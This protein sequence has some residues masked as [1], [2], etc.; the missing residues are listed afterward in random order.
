MHCVVLV[1]I[2]IWVWKKNLGLQHK[3]NGY[4]GEIFKRVPCLRNNE[5]PL[6][7]SAKG[8]DTKILKYEKIA[9][10]WSAQY[11]NLEFLHK[12]KSWAVIIFVEF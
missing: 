11:L 1:N 3:I 2:W 6:E 9:A 12:G 7:P 10:N 8:A 4:Y 5:V